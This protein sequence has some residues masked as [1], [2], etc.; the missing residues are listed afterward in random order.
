METSGVQERAEASTELNLALSLQGLARPP[1]HLWR[2]P[3]CPICIQQRFHSDPDKS[4]GHS[5][6]YWG[7]QP[8]LKKSRRSWPTSFHRR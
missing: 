1:K 2:Q 6:Q 8:G 5:E 7:P 4:A 3:R